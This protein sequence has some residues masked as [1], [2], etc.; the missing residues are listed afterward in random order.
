MSRKRRNF[1][2]SFKAKVALE[3]IQA[4][5]FALQTIPAIGASNGTGDWLKLKNWRFGWNVVPFDGLATDYLSALRPVGA[6]VPFEDF[7]E[8]FSR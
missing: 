7:W 4:C 2:P 1:N 8:F 6:L 3:S 5:Q